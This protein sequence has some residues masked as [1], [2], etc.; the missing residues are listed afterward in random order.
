M[1]LDHFVVVGYDQDPL[2][3]LRH[4]HGVLGV[5]LLAMLLVLQ[6]V[7]CCSRMDFA[8]W[9][10]VWAWCFTNPI[11]Q[12]NTSPLTSFVAKILETLVHQTV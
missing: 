4:C 1:H 6:V 11:Q 7:L 2:C 3:S 10:C 8:G 12:K 5:T 9:L